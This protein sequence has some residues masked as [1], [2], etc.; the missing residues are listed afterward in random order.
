MTGK[1]KDALTRQADEGARIKN[2][3]HLCMNS[4]AEFNAPP[5]KRIRVDDAYKFNSSQINKIKKTFPIDSG[6]SQQFLV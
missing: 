3:A 4:K 1:F 5:I 2:L 6:T